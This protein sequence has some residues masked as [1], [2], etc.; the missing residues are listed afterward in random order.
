MEEFNPTPFFRWATAEEVYDSVPCE[1]TFMI[2]Y[3]KVNSEEIAYTVKSCLNEFNPDFINCNYIGHIGGRPE[4][5]PIALTGICK[6]QGGSM[7][8]S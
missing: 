4:Y 3:I 1:A 6:D 8:V 5:L 2:Y 7:L